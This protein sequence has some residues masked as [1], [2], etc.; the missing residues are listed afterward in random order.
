VL[1]VGRMALE[2]R[3]PSWPRTSPSATL[4]VRRPS[5]CNRS[6]VWPQDRSTPCSPHAIVISTADRVVNFA[7]G[8][9]A[10]F[11]TFIA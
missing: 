6:Q 10:T 9:M 3:A 11:T 5:S 1:E 8:E 4:L 7:Q 2:G